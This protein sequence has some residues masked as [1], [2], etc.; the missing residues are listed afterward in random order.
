MTTIAIQ[1]PDEK[2][3]SLRKLAES[4]QVTLEELATAKVL[5]MLDEP[6]EDFRKAF[7]YVLKK[8]IDLYRRLA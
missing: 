7:Q 1:L 3:K 8:N 2:A 4:S 6:S 5:S